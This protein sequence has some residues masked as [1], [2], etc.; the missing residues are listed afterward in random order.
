[1]NTIYSFLIAFILYGYTTAADRN[2]VS[3]EDAKKGEE[4]FKNDGCTAYHSTSGEIKY[5]PSL[6][7]ILNKPVNV[8]RDGKAETIIVNRKYLIRSIFEPDYQKVS[9]F[10]KKKMPKPKISLEDINHIV[11]YLIFVNTHPVKSRV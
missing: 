9:A 8:I 5:G 4:L 10:K 1:V 2:V 7:N 11:D 6:N 3:E